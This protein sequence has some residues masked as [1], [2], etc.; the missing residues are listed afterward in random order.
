V[1]RWK[2]F[3]QAD[4]DQWLDNTR[5]SI[6]TTGVEVQLDS[7]NK[8][9]AGCLMFGQACRLGPSSGVHG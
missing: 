3:V 7:E 8:D 2:R 6:E 4:E 9:T 5:R 1:L